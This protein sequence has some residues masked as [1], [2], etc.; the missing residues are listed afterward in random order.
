MAFDQKTN[1]Y[2]E[3]RIIRKKGK[4]FN[5]GNGVLTVQQNVG[6]KIRG[7]VTECKQEKDLM[8]VIRKDLEKTN[9]KCVIPWNLWC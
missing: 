6:I 3:W 4:S 1:F 2:N 5:F 7:F 9:K 8:F